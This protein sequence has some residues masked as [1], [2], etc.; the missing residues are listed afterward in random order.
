[1][2]RSARRSLS[3]KHGFTLIELM[4]VIA[5][6]AILA[7]IGIGV[8]SNAQKNAR[9]GRRKAEVTSIAHS[10]ESSRPPGSA[11]YTYTTTNLSNDFPKGMP[12]DPVSAMSYCLGDSKTVGTAPTDPTTNATSGCP[13][14][15]T[16]PAGGDA[17]TAFTGTG[18]VPTNLSSGLATSWSVCAN[19]ENGSS[20]YC[21]DSASK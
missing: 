9:D 2:T 5:I 15:G 13:T 12:S 6:I 10:I 20:P 18:S 11:T 4:V 16:V 7:A 21:V 14:G 17:F 8:Y 19:L 1:M 3:S